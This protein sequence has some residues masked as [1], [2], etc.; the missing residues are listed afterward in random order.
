M[1]R[2]DGRWV[3][4]AS[5]LVGYLA[6]EHL[7]GLS[8]MHALDLLARP[9]STSDGSDEDALDVIRRRG[10]EHERRYLDALRA[11][12]RWI[13]EIPECRTD[14]ELRLAA[15][16]TGQA[17]ADGA[18]VIFQA[19][20]FD[21]SG[22]LSWRGHADFLERVPDVKSDSGSPVYEPVDAKLA[23]R[24]KPGAVMQLCQYASQ[25]TEIQHHEP[26]HL[27][28]ELG[29]GERASFRYASVA[30][31][32]RHARRRFE[33]AVVAGVNSAIY[34]E[35][36]LH[37]SVCGWAARCDERRRADDHLT[38]VAGLGRDRVRKFVA[39]GVPTVAALAQT[40]ITSVPRVGALVFD[41][42]RRQ[43]R[44][45]VQA[46]E[47]AA[48]SPPFELIDPSGAG[49]G[50]EGLPVPNAGDL[51]LDLEGDPFVAGGLEYLFG[52]GWIDDGGEFQFKA[53]WGHDEFGERVAFE[54]AV[55]FIG[56]RRLAH[57]DLHVY[58]YAAYERTAFGRLMGKYGTREDEVDALLRGRVLVDLFQ[59]VRQGVRVGV[60][61][62]SLKKLEPLYMAPREAAITDAGS[63]IVEYE[64]WLQT[65]EPLILID[66]EKYNRDDCES[67]WRLH[68]WLEARRPEAEAEFGRP[69]ERPAA[70]IVTVRPADAVEFDTELDRLRDVLLGTL[71]APPLP[72]DAE[73]YAR[74][75]LA[76]LLEFHR[77]EDKPD[78]WHYFSSIT[79]YEPGDLIDDNRAI[80]CLTYVG[81]AGAVD[82]SILH[83]Y[84]FNPGQE[85]KLTERSVVVDPAVHRHKLHH[86][87]AAPSPGSIFEIVSHRGELVL[88]RGKH[89]VAPHPDAV[90]E[91]NI[92][93]TRVMREAIA[94]VAR[95]W[96][97]GAE[98][99][100]AYQAVRELLRR[101]PPRFAG[102]AG[103]IPLLC[104]GE[105]TLAAAS[106]LA[107]ALDR[108]YLPIQGPPGT[109]K[110]FTAAHVICDLIGAGRRVGIMANSHEVIGHV[111]Q[112]VLKVAAAKGVTIRAIQKAEDEQA[113]SH[114]GITIVH[115]ADDVEDALAAGEV[116][117]V[118]GTAWLFAR[119][120]MIDTLDH[121][122]IDEAGQVSLAN[123]VAAGRA[124]AN[125][126]LVGDPQQLAQP[127]TGSHPHGAGVSVLDHVLAGRPTVADD[128]GLFL[129]T[130]WRMHP[131]VC[132]FI[133]DL[134]YE[135]RLFAHP[136]CSAQSVSG[137]DG[138]GG[139]GVRWV[140]VPHTG[141][142]LGSD[143]EVAAVRVCFDAL[144]GREWVDF[145]GN[146]SPITSHDV[147]IVA[148][149]N[150]QVNKLIA[151]LPAG[152]RVGTVDKFQ[153]QEAAV[154]IV[155]MA[156]SS[157]AD[158]PRGLAFLLSTNRLNVAV[159][160]ARALAVVVASPTLLATECKSLEQIQLVN[161]L[162]RFA[163]LAPSAHPPPP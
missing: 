122:V 121:L 115:H 90:L 151:G 37:C 118:A 49:R 17:I 7:N 22:P 152:A 76:H 74:W 5:A 107:L 124:A 92:F 36:V 56:A 53:F 54:S 33:A 133:S 141:N 14:D 75:V 70:S 57:P 113:C 13:V 134:A 88:K 19:T 58:H 30:A 96:V 78:W 65:H 24:V 128:H 35:P 116:Q 79:A 34:P 148:P 112:E 84:S 45:Q 15:D 16:L 48:S 158:A 9:S 123:V 150:V 110:T 61:S 119:P 85:H 42:L 126:V 40:A 52:I 156:T 99:D 135:S 100:G 44:L 145:D 80:D 127:M 143:E 83:R 136:N 108:S 142:K 20:F 138:L 140:P 157:A 159:S 95:G 31:Y 69:L 55:D 11:E 51:Y 106:R 29:D 28:V 87:T 27:H 104:A 32:F 91:H 139:S 117:L 120:G 137:E 155:S 72:D 105:D 1:Y 18:D 50:L 66:I 26:E 81:E 146:T 68:Q 43:A 3:V 39:A 98:G 114:P 38:L 86:G 163:E 60:E 64:R 129:D 62:Y 73:A 149:Y 21:E 93:G 89:S 130:T 82:A 132:E 162:C 59:V 103:G 63:S 2:A 153:G 10:F 12:D 144:V 101:A 160:R 102:R 94:D 71:E 47:A 154:A 6:C 131:D 46:R 77:R 4:S 161:G 23:H 109:G 25:L 41:R 147:V 125:L 97:T 111:L 8:M 67:T